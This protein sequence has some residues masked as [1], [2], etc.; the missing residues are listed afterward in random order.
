MEKLIITAAL[1]GAEVSRANQPN[2]P[3]SPV[4][5][6][7][8]ALKCYEAGASIVHIHARTLD[9]EPTQEVS[10]YEAIFKEI[11]KRCPIIIQP[12]TGGAVWHTFDQRMAPLNLNPEMA[13]LSC[14]T[15]NFGDDVF[16]NDLPFMRRLAGHML[17]H[18][19]K[20][21]LEI[22]ERGMIQNALTL[23]KEGLLKGPLHFDLVLG[24]PGACPGSIEDLAYM[25]K[26]LPS[27]ATWTVAGVGR[28][29]LPLTTMAILMGGHVR[30][31]F[32]DNIY[33]EKGRLASSNADFVARVVR[34]AKE[35]GREIATPEDARRILRLK[36]V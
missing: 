15:C 29:Q 9:G 10:Y 14:G 36:S 8:E 22:F 17:E 23:E 34:I 32:E 28:S 7:E 30:V 4:E 24:V 19:I 35:L 21:E 25:V 33:Y 13:T 1:T 5:I 2:L 20:P 26:C 18:E 27:D 12:T 16:Q 3:L 11:Q 31:G 6:A